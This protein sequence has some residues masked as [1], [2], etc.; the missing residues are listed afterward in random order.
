MTD[1][2][3]EPPVSPTDAKA[4]YSLG[5]VVRHRFLDFR[6]VIFDVDPEFNNTEEWYQAIPSQFRPAREQPFYHLFAENEDAF[7]TA[8]ASQQNLVPDDE[9]MPIN[10]PDIDKYFTGFANGIYLLKETIRN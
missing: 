10:H 1:E 8:Y 6:G 5:Q 4:E 9:K 7:Y 3:P 2:R